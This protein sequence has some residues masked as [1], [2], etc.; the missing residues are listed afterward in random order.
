[1]TP[2]RPVNVHPKIARIQPFQNSHQ[3]ELQNKH[4][5]VKTNKQ[6]TTKNLSTEVYQC[7]TEA[8]GGVH[9]IV[10]VREDVLDNLW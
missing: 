9:L 8:Q 4:H 3:D 7:S 1:M 5:L 10:E 6:K 2:P